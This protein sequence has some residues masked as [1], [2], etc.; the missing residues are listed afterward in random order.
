MIKIEN[1]IRLQVPL[2]CSM[3]DPKYLTCSYVDIAKIID[4]PTHK[5]PQG[6]EIVHHKKNKAESKIPD[7]ENRKSTLE[8]I[9]NTIKTEI[10]LGI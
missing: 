9:F 3:L 4:T 6:V 1:G 7:K 5:E 8:E 2:I 10:G